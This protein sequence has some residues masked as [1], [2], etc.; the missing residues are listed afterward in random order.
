MSQPPW[1]HGP[2]PAYGPPP[3]WG[4]Q[5]GPGYGYVQPP[6]RAWPAAPPPP[7]MQVGL[8]GLYVFRLIMLG[9]V[10]CG[11]IALLDYL[12]RAR[13]FP[14]L[15]DAEGMTLRSGT[16]VSWRELTGVTRVRYTRYGFRV[17]G[18]LELSF[19]R[20]TALIRPMYVANAEQV[21]AYISQVTGRP[22][23]TG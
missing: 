23:S 17:A 7:G 13:R 22:L 20:T 4:Q 1:G 10:S 21:I 15:V 5:Q 11:L 18:A 16:R 19:G 8:G 6:Q 14:K 9:L 2:P 3:G 12:I